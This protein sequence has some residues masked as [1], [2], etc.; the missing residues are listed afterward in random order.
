LTLIRICCCAKPLK[1]QAYQRRWCGT[2]AVRGP[3]TQ[4]L[5]VVTDR[6]LNGGGS[7]DYFYD[8]L[9]KKMLRL[10]YNIDLT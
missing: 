8:D 10:Y 2:L 5:P 4:W 7:E 6:G 9:T 3:L 1:P